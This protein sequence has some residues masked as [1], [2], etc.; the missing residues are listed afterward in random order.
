METLGNRG[1]GSSQDARHSASGVLRPLGAESANATIGSRIDGHLRVNGPA[2]GVVGPLPPAEAASRRPPPSAISALLVTQIAG[3]IPLWQALAIACLTAISLGSAWRQGTFSN[4]ALLAI[5]AGLVAGVSS[6]VARRVQSRS[7]PAWI[8][9][10]AVAAL[11]LSNL[12]PGLDPGSSPTEIVLSAV[13]AGAACAVCLV[14]WGRQARL[15]ALIGAGTDLAL[16]ASRMVW[17]QAGIDVFWFTQ[18]ST[19]RL[20]H[21]LNPYGMAYPTTTP[22]LLSAHFPYGPALLVL[23]APFRLLGDIRVANAAA[24]MLLFACIAI[25]ARRHMGEAAAGRY[26]ALALAMP[27]SP[28]MI[29]QAWPEVYPVAG[30]ALWLVLRPRHPRWAVLALGTGL[31]TV[32]T[33]LPLLVFVWLWWRD[34]RRE[35]TLAV[36][37]ALLACVPFALWAGV[38]NFIADTVLLQLRLAPRPDALSING[39]LAHLGRP[40]LPG[41]A[42]VSLSAVCLAAFALWGA[43]DW[44]AALLMGAVLTLLAFVTAKWAFFDYYFIVAVG[45]VLALVFASP[46]RRSAAL[47]PEVGALGDAS[48]TA[49][50]P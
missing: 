18:R 50:A 32:P 4:A 46:E 36:L 45:I 25:L 19:E 39:L 7:V 48:S 16:A 20:L 9:P 29:V 42:G 10:L 37:V 5:L 44:D 3:R 24:M 13:L 12:A 31:C 30:V 41:W 27:F 17:G 33:A 43:K 26:V 14:G 21:G 8:W 22:G 35:I 34:A 1:A 15:L 47:R 23:A 28:F 40:L 49:E 11:A 6:V 38:G 2:N